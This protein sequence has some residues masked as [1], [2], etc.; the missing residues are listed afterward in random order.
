MIEQ[1]RLKRLWEWCGFKYSPRTTRLDTYVETRVLWEEPGGQRLR[2]ALPDLTL[3][4]LFKWV[5]P[6]VLEEKGK[7]YVVALVNNALCDSIETEGKVEE[8]IFL[9]VEKLTKEG[10]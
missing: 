10:K 8:Y 9:A 6:K 1:E 7:V 2:K 3:N 4:N 5:L